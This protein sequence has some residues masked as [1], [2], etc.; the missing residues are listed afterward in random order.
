MK[1]KRDSKA[2]QKAKKEQRELDNIALFNK[3]M[4]A[5]NYDFSIW[6]RIKLFFKR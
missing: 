3:K 1:K 4:K 5:Y 2:L 6:E